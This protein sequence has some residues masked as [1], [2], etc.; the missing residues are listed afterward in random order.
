M[1]ISVSG[2]DG[3]LIPRMH[4]LQELA[5]SLDRQSSVSHNPGH[6]ECIDGVVSGNGENAHAVRHYDVRALPKYA[7]AGFF[8]RSYSF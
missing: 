3:D 2:R 6:R 5:E 7:K 8:E 1:A 4:S